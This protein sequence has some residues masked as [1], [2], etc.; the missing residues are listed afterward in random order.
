MSKWIGV[1]LDGTLAE[2]HGAMGSAIGEPVKPMLARVREW[3]DAGREVRIFTARASD[4][5]QIPAIRQWL[6][7]HG[8]GQLAITNVKDFGMQ[9]LYDDKAMRVRRNVGWICPNCYRMKSGKA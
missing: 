2:Y 3:L 1:D 5:A 8:L 6:A 7:T 9:E 4:P